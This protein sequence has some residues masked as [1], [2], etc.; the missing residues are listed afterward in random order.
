MHHE[1][2]VAVERAL[3]GKEE[4]VAKLFR[5]A[6]H[7]VDQYDSMLSFESAV[8]LQVLNGADM[9]NRNHGRK[10][11]AEMVCCIAE[12]WLEDLLAFF[13][14]PHPITGLKPYTGSMM[15]KVTD[16][17]TKQFQLQCQVRGLVVSACA[18]VV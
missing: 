2:E 14:Q 9:G 10:A 11:M 16:N 3:T 17:S 6:L 13:Q 18:S 12:L 5:T 4:L 7:T 15:D 1:R 8:R